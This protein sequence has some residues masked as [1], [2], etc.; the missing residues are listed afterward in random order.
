[1][2]RRS[3]LSLSVISAVGFALLPSSA[4]SQQKTLKEQI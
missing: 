2:N 1:M 3:I 4:V